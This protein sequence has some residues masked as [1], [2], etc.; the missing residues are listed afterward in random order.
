MAHRIE[1][2]LKS[3]FVDAAADAIAS[4]IRE[5]F[6]A[7]EI[8]GVSIIEVYSIDGEFSENDLASI[9]SN[10]LADP[11]TQIFAVDSPV[12]SDF[13]HAIEVS[14]RP[15]VKD[16][17]GETASEGMQDVLGRKIG[18]SVYTSKLY[19]FKGDFPSASEK[20]IAEGILC[21]P[22]IQSWKSFTP[23]TVGAH[24]S[25]I[26]L[27]KAG[28]DAKGTVLEIPLDGLPD[29]ELEKISKRR[30]LALNIPEMKAIA[31]YYSKPQTMA[32]RAKAGISENPTDVELECLA[33][34]WSEHCKHKIFNA[35][36]SYTF[37]PKEG[38]AQK[39]E[40]R[41]LFKTYIAGTTKKIQKKAGYLVSVFTDGAGVMRL[42]EGWNFVMKVETHNT[43]SALD[44]YGGALTGI[45]G[46]NRDV[47]GV[48]IGA[49]PIFNTDVFCFAD[50]FYTGK[51]PPRLLH[52][53]RVFEGVRA[54]VERGGNA[55]GIPTVNGSVFFDERY[56][57]KP[58][59]YCGTG[60]IMP[61][62][63]N[64]A[65]THEK[66]IKPGDRIF[67]VGGRIGKDG[68]HGATFS[69]EA[70]HEGSPTSAVQLGDPFTQK[71][72]LDFLL[73]ARDAGLVS[74]LQDMGAGGI[75]S[76]VGEMASWVG[77]ALV[78]LERAPLKYAGLDPWEILVSESQE[79]MAVAVP[80]SKA[81]EFAA[82]AQKHSVEATDL[83]EFTS[84]GYFHVL[85][86]GHPVAYLPLEFLH[87]GLPKM[88][89][90]AKWDTPQEENES[91]DI[92]ENLTA[93]LL[94]LLSRPNIC[95]KE[96]I[97]RQ[98]DHEVTG[99]SVVKPMCGQNGTGPS[100]SAVVQP[101]PDKD[102]GIAVS[103]GMCV[104]AGDIDPYAMATLAVDEAV[105]NYV[106]SGGNPA[107]WGA[108]DNFCWPDP[109]Q[110]SSN[111]D[112]EKKLGALV[113]ANMG[114]ADACLAY[115][116]PLISGKDSMKNDYKMGA[117]KIS[118]PPT[119]LISI[120]GKVDDVASAQT[121]DFKNPGDAI[122]LLG[123]TADAMGGSEYLQAKGM[124]GNDAPQVDFQANFHLYKKLHNAI[125]NGLVSSVHDISDGG[126][127]V[128][129]AECC[130]GGALGCEVE[131]SS[132]EKMRADFLLFS[133]S[134]GRFI[135]SV[136][137]GKCGGFEKAMA[138][139]M[140]EKI[141]RVSDGNEL[142]ISING[143]S[144]ISCK[145]GEMEKSFKKTITW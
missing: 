102:V 9:G 73:A 141:G 40:I 11:L 76:S 122:Y 137:G 24:Y 101:F 87:N 32:S 100:D 117:W 46:V 125:A 49:Q 71:K 45:L 33:Q 25:S 118:I 129:L 98:Y 53:K 74:G 51:I 116:L 109:V 43:P 65:P 110:S 21:N 20:T 144:S 5:D 81:G 60:G 142:I 138:G 127:A 6:G 30:L 61:A 18:G 103:H 23:H 8:T 59:V 15:G 90:E 55:S 7:R 114:L 99:I 63:I 42:C 58:V 41:S 1:V 107:H 96:S 79:R 82:M 94:S 131:V 130:I 57:G 28:I 44:P 134:P 140:F 22:L 48:G 80:P 119:L 54:G 88:E 17:V 86:H 3:E 68:I 19:L 69:S 124:R 95:S 38:K 120:V 145:V 84:S 121:T 37:T 62:K 108:L 36:I 143:K 89:L 27:P 105:R 115:F 29:H 104:H 133:E 139:C 64:G 75:S 135:V 72:V 112:G 10:L 16:N 92:P 31:E 47:I 91:F 128:A 136:R 56:L 113:L 14:F 85:F 126:L 70:L 123:K 66:P 26:S 39:K 34:T 106:A 35:K 93:E 67:T 78:H 13:S 2:A 97:V 52:P 12:S 111:P 77:G 83:G 4:R 50:P 132:H